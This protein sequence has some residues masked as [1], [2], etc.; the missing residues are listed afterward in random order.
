MELFKYLSKV[1]DPSWNNVIG[2]YLQSPEIE[3]I[4]DAIMNFIKKM[5]AC[6]KAVYPAGKDVF[7]AF[8]LPASNIKVVILGQDPY[9]GAGQ[10]NGLAFSVSKDMAIPPSLANI[11]KEIKSDLGLETPNHGCLKPWA[12]EGIFLLNTVLSVSAGLAQSHR[13]IGWEGFTDEVISSL[14]QKGRNLV[15]LLWGREAMS[16]ESLIDKKKHL[17][18]KAA[19]PSP[20]SAHNGFFGCKHFSKTNNYLKRHGIEPVS[21]SLP[22]KEDHFCECKILSYPL[23]EE[24]DLRRILS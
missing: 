17:V 8:R 7:N 22:H 18:L 12:S 16:K 9:H 19:H 10:A 24:E 5:K 3:K 13:R 1:M 4:D 14:S 15:F 23:S 20:L 11:F 21:W 2:D 6:G